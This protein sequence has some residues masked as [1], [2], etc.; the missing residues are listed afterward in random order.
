MAIS[1][2]CNKCGKELKKFGGLIF[3]PP[4]KQNIVK[5][6]HICRDCFKKLTKSFKE[7]K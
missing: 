3:S 6:Y 2:I 7:K 5:K 4:T 1:P